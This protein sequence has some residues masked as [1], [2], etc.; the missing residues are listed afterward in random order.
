MSKERRRDAKGIIL[1]SNE[2]LLS[3]P[4]NNYKMTRMQSSG[5]KRY[6]FRNYS[7]YPFFA[8]SSLTLHHHLKWIAQNDSSK[9]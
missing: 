3:S 7:L 1:A 5:H 9:F 8:P 2:D 6:T 4:G